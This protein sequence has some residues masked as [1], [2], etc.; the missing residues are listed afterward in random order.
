MPKV[1]RYATIHGGEG[2]GRREA[3]N[4]LNKK[5][6]RKRDREQRM[7]RKRGKG[8]GGGV[9]QKKQE[10]VN[11]RAYDTRKRYLLTATLPSTISRTPSLPLTHIHTDTP[12]LRGAS[13]TER[14]PEKPSQRGRLR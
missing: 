7:L 10:R 14:E 11:P 12:K 8:I 5:R 6:D 3:T 2:C 13:G 1:A 9:Q 4:I